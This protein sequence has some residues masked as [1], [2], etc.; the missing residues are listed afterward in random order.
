MFNLII[1]V[2]ESYGIG[3]NNVL[4]WKC[5]DDLKF[6]KSTTKGHILIVGRN[7]W[8]HMPQSLILKDRNVIV[9]S[10]TLTNSCG[11]QIATS[12]DDALQ[13]AYAYQFKTQ[14]IYVIGGLQLY[15]DAFLHHDLHVLY[16]T[17]I[18]G[19]HDCDTYVPFLKDVI[20]ACDRVTLHN[21]TMCKIGKYI[22]QP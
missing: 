5:S 19:I 20:N 3:K 2:D 18:D 13:I 6:F 16:I 4:P 21:Y 8:T 15:K 22:R 7:T 14:E 10:T 9:V 12:L 1:A 11:V 17:Y